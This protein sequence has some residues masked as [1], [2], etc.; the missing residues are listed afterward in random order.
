MPAKSLLQPALLALTAHRRLARLAL[1]FRDRP[2]RGDDLPA[3]HL[4][5]GQC[6]ADGVE[7]AALAGQR[8]LR[9]EQGDPPLRV[10]VARAGGIRRPARPVELLPT[11][12]ERRGRVVAAAQ[13]R[14]QRPHG[15][16]RV[17]RG[18]QRLAG[19]PDGRAARPCLV[20]VAFDVGDSGVAFG[21]P[22]GPAR[23]PGGRTDEL[24]G[25]LSRRARQHPDPV[26][27]VGPHRAAGRL[28][29]HPV[30]SHPVRKPPRRAR[31][32]W[33]AARRRARPPRAPAPRRRG[34]RP[35]SVRA[36][37]CP[38]AGAPAR[39]RHRRRRPPVPS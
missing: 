12:D 14:D 13:S 38:A 15:R 37:G 22:R 5:A 27:P 7:P 26:P 18:V 31:R 36:D 28:P 33:P 21:Q 1:P 25:G 23:R 4:H 32:R 39:R 16:Q 20:H 30:P 35:A 9:G 34:R 10:D 2:A 17:P 29:S 19:E 11:R 3:R 24:G 8:A 6:P